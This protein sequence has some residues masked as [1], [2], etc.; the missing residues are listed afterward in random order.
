VEYH[1]ELVKEFV[2]NYSSEYS[3][4]KTIVPEDKTEEWQAR[5]LAV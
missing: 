3:T 2:S 1:A 4:F 5:N